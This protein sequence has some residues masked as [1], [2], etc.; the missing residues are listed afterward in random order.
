MTD[1]PKR[2][3]KNWPLGYKATDLV[4]HRRQMATVLPFVEELANFVPRGEVPI[5][6]LHDATKR[7]LVWVPA[8]DLELLVTSDPC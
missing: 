8:E 3:K 4:F 2:W 1:S 7:G 5:G 6:Y